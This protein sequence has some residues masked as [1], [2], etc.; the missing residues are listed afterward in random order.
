[1]KFSR[2]SKNLKISIYKLDYE[3]FSDE[4]VEMEIDGHRLTEHVKAKSE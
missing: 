1:M 2:H 3:I 4:V